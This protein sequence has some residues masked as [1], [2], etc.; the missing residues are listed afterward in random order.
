MKG[1]K[2]SSL[3]ELFGVDLLPQYVENKGKFSTNKSGIGI[4]WIKAKENYL[5]FIFLETFL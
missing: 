5:V 4:D 1:E 3:G 2:K